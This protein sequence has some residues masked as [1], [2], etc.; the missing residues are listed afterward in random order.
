[1]TILIF[2]LCNVPANILTLIVVSYTNTLNKNY[3][4]SVLQSFFFITIFDIQ[5]GAVRMSRKNEI[6]ET[7]RRIPQLRNPEKRREEQQHTRK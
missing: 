5:H 6:A 7:T 2:L 3:Y 4:N 1:M